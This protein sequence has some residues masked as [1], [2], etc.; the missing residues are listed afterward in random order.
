VVD[1]N[2]DSADSLSLLLGLKGH[3]VRTAYDGT[4]AIEAARA[5]RPDVALLDIGL[6]GLDGYE[7]ARRIRA[8]ES[9]AQ[10]AL[11]A[12]TGWG[13][14]E[15]KRRAREAGFDYHMTKPISMEAL[16]RFLAGLQTAAPSRAA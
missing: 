14:A 4:S 12:T 13:H 3:H 7:V 16:E 2:R 6:P 9:I 11:V 10:P 15:D 1:D 5:F 8:E